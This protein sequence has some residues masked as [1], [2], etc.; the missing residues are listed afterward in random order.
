M[1]VGTRP[2]IGVLL[3]VVLVSGSP[4]AL[5]DDLEDGQFCSLPACV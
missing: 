4:N 2:W 5:L 3:F 1:L